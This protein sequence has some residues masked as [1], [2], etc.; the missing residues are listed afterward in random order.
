M[1]G[2]GTGI[3]RDLPRDFPRDAQGLGRD[4]HRDGVRK[5][6]V[7]LEDCLRASRRLAFETPFVDDTEKLYTRECGVLAGDTKCEPPRGSHS[8]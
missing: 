4:R 1:G 2:F 5:D 3:H 7:T 6:M 8:T